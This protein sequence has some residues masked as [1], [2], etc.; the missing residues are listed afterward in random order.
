VPVA[1]EKQA[2]LTSTIEFLGIIIDMNRQELCL[3]NCPMTSSKPYWPPGPPAKRT[4][5]QEK[6]WNCS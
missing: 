4:P 3:P 5:A 6:N 1:P 2:G